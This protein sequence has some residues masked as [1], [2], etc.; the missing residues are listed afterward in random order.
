MHFTMR[1]ILE[2]LELKRAYQLPDVSLQP[3]LL[4]ICMLGG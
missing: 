1:L 4:E 3:H 2:I